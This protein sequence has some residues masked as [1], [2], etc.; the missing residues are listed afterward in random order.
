MSEIQ[1]VQAELIDD[2]RLFDNWIDRYQYIIDLG[3]DL[4]E[5]PDAWRSE[6]NRIHG[7]QSQVWLKTRCVDG[8]LDFTAV[9]DSAIVSGLIAILMR[10]YSGQSAAEIIAASPD[11]IGEIGLDEHL[12]PTRSNGLHSMIKAIKG[13]AGACVGVE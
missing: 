3:K 2:F 12:S 6:E 11:F 13:A 10:V 8:R 4:P 5:F 1:T 7:C 9:S